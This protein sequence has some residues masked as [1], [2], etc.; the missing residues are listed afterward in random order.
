MLKAQFTLLQSRK[1][2]NF[3]NAIVHNIKNFNVNFVMFKLDTSRNQ[4]ACFPQNSRAFLGIPEGCVVFV[5]GN[6]PQNGA[7][8]RHSDTKQLQNLHVYECNET[9]LTLPIH[10]VQQQC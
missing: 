2:A 4:D 10:S 5:L 9:K 7:V 6:S 1:E 8:R 3:C